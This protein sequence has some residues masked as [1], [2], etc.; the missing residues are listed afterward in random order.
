MKFQK[1]TRG[2]H[3]YRI[4]AEDGGGSHPIHGAINVGGWGTVM[5]WKKDGLANSFDADGRYDL[6]PEKKRRFKT[7]EELIAC[8][9]SDISFSCYG[10]VDVRHE[11][12]YYT[13]T[14]SDTPEGSDSEKWIEVFT[15][16][17]DV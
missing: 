11:A 15:V 4:Y 16:E 9:Y 5:I 6:L 12:H 13:K 10:V 17:E 2:G 7:N 14:K 3:E 1:L 8:Q